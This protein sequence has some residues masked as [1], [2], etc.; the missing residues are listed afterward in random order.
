MQLTKLIEFRQQIYGNALTKARDAQ[1]DLIDALLSNRR[2]SSL[3]ELSLAP[4]HQR[5]WHSAYAALKHGQQDVAWLRQFLCDQVP[6]QRDARSRAVL[7]HRRQQGGSAEHRAFAPLHNAHALTRLPN[8]MPSTVQ[9]RE[10]SRRTL[11][12]DVTRCAYR[13]SPFATS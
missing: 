12:V 6:D 11:R 7:D 3:P 13:S 10:A 9:P 1:F 2:I 4:V 8:G 5:Q